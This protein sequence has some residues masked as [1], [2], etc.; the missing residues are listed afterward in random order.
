MK[1]LNMSVFSFML[2]TST[3]MSISAISWFTAWLGLEIN[4]IC[5]MP[6]MKN[7]K[8]KY[9]SEATIKYFIV[10]AISSMILLFSILV[11][12]NT[13]SFSMNPAF[14]SSILINL[15]LLMKMGAAPLHFWFPE[16]ISGLNWNL[17]LI[18]MTW[19]KIA[20]MIL[21][22]FSSQPPLLMNMFIIASATVGSIMGLNQTCLRKIL[23]YSSINHISWMLAAML[24]SLLIWLLYFMIYVIINISIISML[25][26]YNIYFMNQISSM[27]SFNSNMKMIFCLNMLS[28][29]GLPPFLGFYP[30]WITINS[31][32]LSGFN[33]T[34]T[35]MILFSLIALFLYLRLVYPFITLNSS[36][37]YKLFWPQTNFIVISSTLSILGMP[38]M[39]LLTNLL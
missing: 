9:S 1:N 30:K 10:Q 36:E 4:L 25:K 20:P 33:Y 14:W 31:L 39:M 35:L 37:H 22:G 21:M 32:S 29:G 17:S 34:A 13:P 5:L 26:S 18:I 23:A 16:V 11:F 24:N 27:F 15:A 3:L 28:L 7:T 12:M 6:L 19:Q 38:C 2:V 8:N